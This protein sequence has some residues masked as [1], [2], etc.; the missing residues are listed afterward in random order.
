MEE[1]RREMN[2]KFLFLFEFLSVLQKYFH[3]KVGFFRQKVLTVTTGGRQVLPFPAA[4]TSPNIGLSMFFEKNNS[5]VHENGVLIT[6][7]LD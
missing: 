2:E 1:R 4:K 3:S 5:A 7:R 6:C